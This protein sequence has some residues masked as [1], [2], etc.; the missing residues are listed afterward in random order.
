MTFPNEDFL[1][2]ICHEGVLTPLTLKITKIALLKSHSTN[3]WS[4]LFGSRSNI[5]PQFGCYIF[6]L[7]NVYLN[8]EV[9]DEFYT[10]SFLLSLIAVHSYPLIHYHLISKSAFSLYCLSFMDDLACKCLGHPI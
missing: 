10:G 3:F 4:T 7:Q 5:L 2:D 8:Q 6:I 9:Q 1:S